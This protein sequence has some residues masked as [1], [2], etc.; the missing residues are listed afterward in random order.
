MTNRYSKILKKGTALCYTVLFL[1]Y[2]HIAGAEVQSVFYFSQP[3]IEAQ[4]HIAAL[5][6]TKAQQI[7]TEEKK[8]HPNNA[9]IGFLE[10]Y[11]DFY[12]IATSL[13]FSTFKAMDENKSERFEAAKNI[14]ETSP[15][16][17]YTQSEMYLQFAFAKA[18][19]EE[20]V[21]AM[22]DFR[23][24]YQLAVENQKKFPSFKQS[25]KTVGMFKALLGTTGKSYKWVLSVAGLKGNFDEGMG[26]LENYFDTEFSDEFL[27]DKQTATFYYVLLHLNFGDKQLA[28]KFCEQRTRDYATNMMSNY[29]RGYTGMRTAQ[30]EEAINVLQSR[31]KSSDYEPF[32]ALEYYYALCKLYRLDADA[33]IYFKHFI[34]VNKNKVLTKEAYKRLSWFYLVNNDEEKFRIYYGM[35]KRY[36]GSQNEDDKNLQREISA[37]T[38]H[39]VIVLKSRL[40]ADGGYYPKAEETIRLRPV[41]QFASEYQRLEYYF[42][43]ARIL[44]EQN[45]F[46]KA[47]E[48][49]QLVIKNSP[50]NTPYHFAP[51]ANVYVGQIY[52]KLG[53]TQMA[54]TYFV[55]AAKYKKAEYIETAEI[56]AGK[57]LQSLK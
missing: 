15:Y 45:K 43:Y 1:F 51:F 2:F 19:N 18:M 50:D 27:L 47:T 57:E 5:R 9:A 21:S 36:G 56:R 34:S 13:D 12:R 16:R 37:N 52:L 11:I 30:K 53:F 31:P 10:N 25:A 41:D 8:A 7:L 3:C 17:L 42:R 54:K 35:M 4:K 22:L 40:L 44:Q 20:F 32:A 39:D 49:Y 38:P 48:Y 29:L 24:A 6:L 26:L 55:N 23:S 33:D 14:P 28:W 46:S